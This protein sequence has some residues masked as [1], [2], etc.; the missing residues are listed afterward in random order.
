MPEAPIGKA[1][2]L[3]DAK[4]RLSELIR[5]AEKNGETI[6]ITRHGKAVAQIAPA[7]AERKPV[8]LGAMKDRIRLLRGWNRPRSL[9]PGRLVTACL[10][11]TN[12]VL[13]ALAAPDRLSTSARKAVSSGANVISVVS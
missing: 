4:N 2:F 13:L 12:A 8:P 9:S 3:D 11:E 10:L 6:V 5:R 1:A 7:P